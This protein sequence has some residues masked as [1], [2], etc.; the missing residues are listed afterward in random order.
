MFG[1]NAFIYSNRINARVI[2][3]TDAVANSARG[4]GGAMLRFKT[5]RS[6]RAAGRNQPS[7][8]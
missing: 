1:I 3:S 4:G 2:K 7:L 5:T 6:C 8:K